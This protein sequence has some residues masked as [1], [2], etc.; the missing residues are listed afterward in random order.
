MRGGGEFSAKGG[1]GRQ[2]AVPA[3]LLIIF[4]KP[5]IWARYI[6]IFLKKG[7]AVIAH[8]RISMRCSAY[9]LGIAILGRV[10]GEIRVNSGGWARYMNIL[11]SYCLLYSSVGKE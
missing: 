7:W 8:E 6:Y 5:I 1:G 2:Q 4:A 10:A 3:I 9:L 11:E